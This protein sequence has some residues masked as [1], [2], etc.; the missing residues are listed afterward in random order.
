MIQ[1]S[2]GIGS[3]FGKFCVGFL[4]DMKGRIYSVKFFLILGFI[5]AFLDFYGIY[6]RNI[7]I[8]YVGQFL[9]GCGYS[10]MTSLN[11]LIIA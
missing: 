10:A 4:A 11:S 9:L 1:S 7:G 5:A 2:L 6:Y 3:I 8:I